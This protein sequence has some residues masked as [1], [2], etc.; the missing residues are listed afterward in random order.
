MYLQKVIS[1]KIVYVCV[2]KVKDEGSRAGPGAGSRSFSQRHGSD[3]QHCPRFTDRDTDLLSYRIRI[4]I[5]YQ[6]TD[7]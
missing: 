6:V 4:P 7:T 2:M 3:P 1:R 5:R